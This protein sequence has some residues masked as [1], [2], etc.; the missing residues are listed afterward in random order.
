MNK[1][2]KKVVIV[3]G[4]TAG[5]M[6]AALLKKVMSSVIDIELIESEEI[7]RIGVGEA[8]IPPIRHFNQTLGIDEAEFLRETNASIK[9]AIK[10]ENW[11]IP[12]ESYFHT[13]GGA[14][15][16]LGFCAFYHFWLRAKSLGDQSSLWEYDL[17]YLCATSNKFA[18]INSKDPALEMQYAFH[19]DASLYAAYLRK[20]SENLGVKR[21]EGLIETVDIHPDSG[22]VEKLKL[23]TGTVVHGD[24]FIDCSGMR[25]LL[26]Q[27][28]LKTAYEDWSHWLPCDRAIAVPSERL[29]ETLPYTRSIAHSAGWQW[30]IPLQHRNGNGIVYSSNHYSQ[31]EATHILL[32][33][34]G[35]KVLGE[36]NFISFKTGRCLKPWS[37]NV[38]AIGL[39]SGFL[40]PLE[41]TSIHLIQS[42]IVR[43]VKLFPHKGINAVNK[44][45]YNRQSK[46]E[47]EQ[48]RDFI[49]LHYHLNE[50]TDGQFWRDLRN[51]NIPSSLAH[52]I[53]LFQET[54]KIFREQDDLFLE[55]SWLQV[56][57]GQG[58]VPQDYHPLANG[59]SEPDLIDMLGNMK[60]IKQSPLHH[61]P[62][63]DEFLAQVCKR[64]T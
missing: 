48:V 62:N 40:E 60:K 9:L 56:M 3:G 10:F 45:E 14:G 61:L 49:I 34:L 50:R 8:T 13:F 21:T 2:I 63:H 4:G 12:G 19:F 57:L 22:Y 6:S 64:S 41:S 37:K 44:D 36:P 54:G 31:D 18:P 20:F 53:K 17:N 28:T 42:A 15:K 27:Q 58:I 16:N 11:R 29:E 1:P 25:G 52:K 38:V 26:I 30:R 7:G 5:W 33:N 39:A 51:M 47:F 43:L 55:S 59:L 35:S 24:L 32:N 23:K 46:I